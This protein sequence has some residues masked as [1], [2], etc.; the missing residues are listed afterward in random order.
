MEEW[1]TYIEGNCGI[2]FCAG[3]GGLETPSTIPDRAGGCH[4]HDVLSNEMT[5][6]IS[7]SV[8]EA[9]A[10]GGG[11]TPHVVLNNVHRVKCDMNRSMSDGC[12]GND[13]MQQALWRSYHDKICCIAKLCVAKFGWCHLFDVHGQSHREVCI[14][15]T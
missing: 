6:L 2:I 4:E 9:I 7:Q 10:S 12:E 8:S 1:I 15:T 13:E 14:H 5:L 11:V 3:H